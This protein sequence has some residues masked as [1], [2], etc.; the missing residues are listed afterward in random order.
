M[1]PPVFTF[2]SFSCSAPFVEDSIRAAVRQ[3]DLYHVIQVHLGFVS[4]GYTMVPARG[5]IVASRPREWYAT[6]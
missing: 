2:F 4:E 6:T 5:I 3:A 1:V